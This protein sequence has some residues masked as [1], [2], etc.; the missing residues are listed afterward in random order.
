MRRKTVDGE[1]RRQWEKTIRE[2]ARSGVSVSH[3]CRQRNLN[4]NQFYW[5]RRRL[6]EGAMSKAN[7][8]RS[9]ASFALVTD[10][11]GALDAGIELVLGDGRRLRIAKGADE[12]TLRAV[13]S[14]LGS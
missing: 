10:Q 2:A 14:A 6:G 8:D 9:Q 13:L 4:V 3:F 7:H 1:K 11:P 5:W 12:D